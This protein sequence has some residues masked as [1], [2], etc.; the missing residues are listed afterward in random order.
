MSYYS[1][2]F[3]WPGFGEVMELRQYR[4]AVNRLRTEN[5]HDDSDP[6]LLKHGSSIG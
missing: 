1:L 6:Y 3:N 2:S 5:K 4:K